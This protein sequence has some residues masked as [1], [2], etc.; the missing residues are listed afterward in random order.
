MK[1]SQ[2]V[3]LLLIFLGSMF[4]ADGVVATGMEEMGSDRKVRNFDRVVLQ[5]AGTLF[6]TQGREE[7]LHIEAPRDLLRRIET[8]VRGGTLYIKIRG[9]GLRTGKIRY[10]LTMRRIEGLKT[11]SSGDIYAGPIETKDLELIS[12]SSGDI[13][14]ESVQV[15]SL[16]IHLSSSGDCTIAGQVD[17]Q[18]V[19]I[20]SSG[21]FEASE[22]KSSR[23][24]IKLSSSGDAVV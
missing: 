5:D 7:S 1:T 19:Q 24:E 20:S 22:L 12:S 6:V 3:L 9:W 23:A 14:V 10:N 13:K 17:E 8:E 18:E 21:D 15:K 16:E 2:K 4:A 11:S